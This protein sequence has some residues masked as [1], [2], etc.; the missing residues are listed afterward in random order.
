MNHKP[1]L[2]LI[3]WN[4]TIFMAL[5]KITAT[6]YSWFAVLLVCRFLS[7]VGPTGGQELKAIG[8]LRNI[9]L[10]SAISMYYYMSLVYYTSLSR[11]WLQNIRR[12]V[13]VLGDKTDLSNRF[14]QNI[15]SRVQ[16]LGDITDLSNRCLQNKH[17]R[18]QI[19]GDITDLSNRCL[20][21]KHSRVQVLGDIT[22]LSN[23]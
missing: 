22:D 18:I 7:L 12:R 2:S 13:Q 11:R 1:C 16:V 6:R 9:F 3:I 14:L 15:R 17:S 4:H 5:V 19:L 10:I 23:R 20:Q 8:K 21:N